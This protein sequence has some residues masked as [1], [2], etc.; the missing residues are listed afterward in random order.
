MEEKP[1][2]EQIIPR[3]EKED[4]AKWEVGEK[5]GIFCMH[6]DK[7]RYNLELGDLFISIKQYPSYMDTEKNK[8]LKGLN[9]LYE[10]T[11]RNKERPCVSITYSS[12][13]T[14]REVRA[15]QKMIEE[16]FKKIYGFYEA[17]EAKKEREHME[18]EKKTH[19]LYKEKFKADMDA[20]LKR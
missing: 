6:K 1:K 5:L 20:L 15:E 7:T 8:L 16:L 12:S 9:Q 2:I 19:G 11:I 13:D 18:Q 3:L 4:L 17:E 14:H 10:L